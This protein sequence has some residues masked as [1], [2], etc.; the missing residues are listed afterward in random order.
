MVQEIPKKDRERLA[1]LPLAV[2]WI[3]SDRKFTDRELR[4]FLREAPGHFD[5]IID[6]NLD[7]MME[8]ASKYLDHKAYGKNIQ[9]LLSPEGKRWLEE[10]G[11]Q[12]RELI[13]S[14]RRGDSPPL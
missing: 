13:E 7:T 9:V 6:R 8:T 10:F 2:N 11:R 1:L 14:S 3:Q 4:A 12:A 5:G